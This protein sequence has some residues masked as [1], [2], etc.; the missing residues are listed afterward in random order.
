MFL[1]RTC[2]GSSRLDLFA[3]KGLA[4]TLNVNLANLQAGDCIFQPFLQP[5]I[6][7][8]HPPTMGCALVILFQVRSLKVPTKD[9]PFLRVPSLLITLL[10]ARSI[11]ALKLSVTTTDSILKGY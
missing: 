7:T 3:R 1:E 5:I 2:D 6:H 11:L 9:R 4:E 8:Y 10:M